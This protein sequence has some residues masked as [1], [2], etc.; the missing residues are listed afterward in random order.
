MPGTELLGSEFSSVPVWR[1]FLSEFEHV[2][3]SVSVVAASLALFMLVQSPACD[4]CCEAC[5]NSSL[6]KPVYVRVYICEYLCLYYM[7]IYT[8]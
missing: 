5:P 1:S 3:W 8:H 6:A 2:F 7:Y 4:C